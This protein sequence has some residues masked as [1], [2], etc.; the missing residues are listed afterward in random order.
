MNLNIQLIS[1]EPEKFKTWA[2]TATPFD[3]FFTVDQF[4]VTLIDLSSNRIWKNNSNNTTSIN[5]IND[6]KSLK[7]CVNNSE[8]AIVIYILPA[9]V[10]FSFFYS[11]SAQKG[12]YDSAP[13]KDILDDIE[14]HVLSEIF[15]IDI[16]DS[17]LFENCSSRVNGVDFHASF[18]FLW[19]WL[20]DKPMMILSDA[21]GSK[22]PTTVVDGRFCFTT[23][24]ILENEKELHTYLQG[25]GLWKKDPSIYPDWLL[26]YDILDDKKQNERIVQSR[27]A[28]QEA[29]QVIEQAQKKRQENFQYK[30][31]LVES[32]EKL[33]EIVFRILE[34]IL[35]I[36]LSQFV[37]KKKE[38]FLIRK[39]NITF[40]GE[41]K[42][43]GTNVKSGAI[44]QVDRHF[45]D[46]QDKLEEEKRQETV[47]QL[48]IINPF[49]DQPLAQ[50]DP[51]HE[52]QINLAKRNGCLI[53]LTE[54]LL[55]I[56][57][58]FRNHQI[59]TSDIKKVFTEKTGL[60]SMDDVPQQNK[61]MQNEKPVS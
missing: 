44:S 18:A 25:I 31:V 1:A 28:I 58:R 15:P 51:V 19:D 47:K 21:N 34:E 45:H 59:T 26:A 27:K 35:A 46:Y 33:V 40:I 32:G 52:N 41:I 20:K 9:N 13:L 7:Q 6:F 43:V 50:R 14:S 61:L 5:I 57:E 38:D 12:Y 23:L 37:D 17:L 60:L 29:Q 39:A 4:D 11:G 56:F 24:Q 54:T 42:G 30:A 53:I 55:K 8:T 49:R 22:K 36:D 16:C 10:P 3:K 48:L 2:L